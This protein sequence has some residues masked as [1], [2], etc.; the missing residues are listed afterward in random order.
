MAY[1]FYQIEEKNTSYKHGLCGSKEWLTLSLPYE[2][3]EEAE[4][5]IKNYMLDRDA[6]RES[7]RIDEVEATYTGDPDLDRGDEEY[8]RLKDEGLL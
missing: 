1:T 7:F 5:E 4:E 2:T 3:E 8:H 6:P